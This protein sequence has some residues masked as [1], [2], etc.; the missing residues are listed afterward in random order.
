MRLFS[1]SSLRV[2]LLL[3]VLSVIIPALGL[4]IYTGM[5]ERRMASDAVR[6]NALRMAGLIQASHRQM[7]DQARVL[8]LAITRFPEVVQGDPVPCSAL[9]AKFKL[10]HPNFLNIGVA[11]LNGDIGCSALPI[12]RV[13]NAADRVWF[14]RA[15]RA[16]DFAVGEYQVGRITGKPSL[17]VAYPVVDPSDQITGVAFIALDLEW[18]SRLATDARLPDGA[19]FTV[20]DQRGTILA[21]H[22]NP[23]EWVG[24]SLPD[25]PL[26]KIVLAEQREGTARATGVDGVSRLYAFMPLVARSQSGHAYLVVGI[27]ERV[28][29]APVNQLLTRSL[30]LLTL[31]AGVALAAAWAVSSAVVVRP[32]STLLNATRQLTAGDLSV[33]ARL[34]GGN[35]H[36]ELGQL[37]RAF[38]EM[39]ASLQRSAAE[40]KSAEQ[41]LRRNMARL[42]TLHAIDQAILRAVSSEATADAALRSIWD[43]IPTRRASVARFDFAANE[44]VV[45]AARSRD[46]AGHPPGARVALTAFGANFEGVVRELRAGKVFELDSR[47]LTGLPPEIPY[48]HLVPLIAEEELL[49][50]LTIAEDQPGTLTDEH[51]EIAREVADQIAV[52][53]RQAELRQVLQRHAEDLER[54]VAERTAEA[55]AARHEADRAN[56]AKS[57]FLSRMS[58]ELRTPMNAVL[59][60]A[61]LLEMDPLSPEQRAAVEHIT[62]AGRHLL[63]L[64]NEV[65][66]IARI[67]AG[68]LTISLEPVL[69]REVVQEAID[70]TTPLA[71][72]WGVSL[73]L[74]PDGLESRHV[75]ADRQRLRQILLNL[76]SNAVK[77]N[78]QG[79]SVV[80]T[81]GDASESRARVQVTDTGPGIP[82][83]RI[84]RLFEPFERL[85]AEDTQIEGTGLGLAH[86]R[87]LAEAMGGSLGVTSVLGQGSTFWIELALVEDPIRQEERQARDRPELIETGQTA[88][89]GILLHIEDNPSNVALIERLLRR[90]PG[91]R[92]V[93]AKLGREGL[94]LAGTHRPDLILLDLHLPDISGHEVLQRLQADPATHDIPVAVISAD[95][96]SG[97]V[98]RL[99]AAGARAYLTK[100]LEIRKLVELFNLALRP[101]EPMTAGRSSKGRLDRE[102]RGE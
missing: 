13:V 100:P 94:E 80:L 37:A 5:Q 95:A 59:G 48:Y 54:R 92:L 36:G 30:L 47:T 21:R 90:Q 99:L 10:Q 29:Y 88:T 18:F 41:S 19:T 67:E 77:Y 32:V 17:N 46:G 6:A 65:L 38:D 75:L 71:A 70:L 20:L 98:E 97:Q 22:P 1:I 68:R 15:L 72:N 79:G 60:F 78:H 24:R 44:V 23:A 61:Q 2:R 74:E 25:A 84:D 12:P 11:A 49:G 53:I 63:D 81:C 9:L 4:A 26:T 96:S 102:T 27:P 28:A 58:H 82:Q 43:L 85:G 7:I 57:D 34:P 73:R 16:R 66:D 83:D 55:D 50:V 93:T 33:R 87:R 69:V 101:R 91:V 51:L 35:G 8:L 31:T 52:A 62:K 42:E 86:S 64:I 56:H 89:T 40:V 45:L 3:L 14:Q 39:A 76:L